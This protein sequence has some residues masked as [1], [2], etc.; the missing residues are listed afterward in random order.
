MSNA[1]GI[2]FLS[3]GLII[4]S[5]GG[6]YPIEYDVRLGVN[7]DS[8]LTG[9]LVLPEPGQ[10][11]T[12]IQYGGAGTQYTGTLTPL[13]TTIIQEPLTIAG[14]TWYAQRLRAFERQLE[15]NGT[16]LS[17]KGATIRCLAPSKEQ[18]KE[19]QRTDYVGQRQA[20]FTIARTD[21]ERYKLDSKSTFTSV[22]S[23]FMIESIL[24]DDADPHVDLVCNLLQ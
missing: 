3:F 13:T 18:R 9:N 24:D 5:G 21:Y 17:Y 12:G 23:K 22:G 10:V 19:I 20:T 1:Q 6:D 11:Q 16:T 8:G 15:I 7:Y 2:A 4:P 14:T